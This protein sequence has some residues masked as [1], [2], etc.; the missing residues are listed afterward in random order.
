MYRNIFSLARAHT[1]CFFTR[2]S[3]DMINDCRSKTLVWHFRD[4]KTT[5]HTH[6]HTSYHS[7][8]SGLFAHTHTRGCE[9]RRAVIN[10][11]RF[12]IWATCACVCVYMYVCMIYMYTL[13]LS[14]CVSIYLGQLPWA[15]FKTNAFAGPYNACT[16]SVPPCKSTS[17]IPGDGPP[18][19]R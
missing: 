14:V 19:A 10:C 4:R 7:L 8:F 9:R 17:I 3:R 13:W 1:F 5:T 12:P 16:R 15:I 11:L 6:T 2:F 18:R